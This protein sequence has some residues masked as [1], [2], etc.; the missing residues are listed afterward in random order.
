[1]H[2]EFITDSIDFQRF[3]DNMLKACWAHSITITQG[4]GTIC[5]SC[6][7]LAVVK[8]SSLLLSCCLKIKWNNF[9]IS[10]RV[11]DSTRNNNYLESRFLSSG[12]TNVNMWTMSVTTSL[13][14]GSKHHTT[15][16]PYGDSLH[17]YIVYCYLPNGVFQEQLLKLLSY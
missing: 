7:Y 16:K 9:L 1:V 13:L 8:L 12:V 4:T 2:H 15:R 6:T 17:T 14:P 5:H 3:S 11:I 10:I